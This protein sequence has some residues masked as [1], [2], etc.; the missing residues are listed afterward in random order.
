M[1]TPLAFGVRWSSGRGSLTLSKTNVFDS[2]GCVGRSDSGLHDHS[3]A[4][5]SKETSSFPSSVTPAAAIT[6]CKILA[7]C[8]ATPVQIN[9]ALGSSLAKAAVE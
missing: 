2:F 3:L 4:S 7:S 1:V 5:S 6:N 9:F 8:P